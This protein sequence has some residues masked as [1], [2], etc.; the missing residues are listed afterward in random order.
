MPLEAVVAIL[1][2]QEGQNYEHLK[3]DSPHLAKLRYLCEVGVDVMTIVAHPDDAELGAGGTLMRWRHE[4][5]RIAMVEL[6][7]GQLGTRGTPEQRWKEAMTAAQLLKPVSRLCLG[8]EDGFFAENPENLKTL[9]DV[10]RRY[11]PRVVITNALS[12]RHPD[13]GRAAQ[14]VERAAWLSGLKKIVTSYPPYRPRRVLF[15]IQ[16]RWQMPSIVVD[17]SDYW[18][19]KLKLIS[20]YRSQFFREVGDTEPES[21]LTRPTFFPHLEARAR[22]MGHFIGVAYGEGFV[23]RGPL[24]VSDYLLL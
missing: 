6:T 15:M 1:G 7:A 24:P 23:M 16:D 10:I 22:E 19:A 9:I 11:Q 18:E 20:A 12:D 14:I 2:A 4:G 3:T 8:W 5:A 21:Y 13:H 17:I